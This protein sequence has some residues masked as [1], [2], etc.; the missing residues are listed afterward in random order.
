MSEVQ[1]ESRSASGSKS[2]TPR[3]FVLELTLPQCTA[4]VVE[5]PLVI[6]GEKIRL[7][8]SGRPP[9]KIQRKNSRA[10]AGAAHHP[11]LTRALITH[12]VSWL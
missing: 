10:S 4:N 6:L 3:L 8:E 2:K 5:M 12:E 11:Q 7:I 9:L 1:T